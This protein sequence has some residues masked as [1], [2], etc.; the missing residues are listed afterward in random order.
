MS[1]DEE[2][3]F[4]LSNYK[5]VKGVATKKDSD[6][7]TTILEININYTVKKPDRIEMF[8]FKN[9]Q[10]QEKFF[11][12]TNNST[13]LSQCFQGDGTL[14]SQ[15]TKW[16]KTLKGVFHSSFRKIR[17]TNKKVKSKLSSLME[18]RRA[19]LGKLKNVADEE[20]EETSAKI[21]KLEEEICELVAEENREKVLNNFKV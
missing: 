11:Q 18:E 13:E 14:E 19:E 2:K 4:V 6:H 10:C 3:K 17:H 9:A 1:I 15:A 20:D 5:K 16:F 7:F 21:T 12:I 8:N